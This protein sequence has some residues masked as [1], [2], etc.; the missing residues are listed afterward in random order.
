MLIKKIFIN[1]DSKELNIKKIIQSY[2]NDTNEISSL[3][4][5]IKIYSEKINNFTFEYPEEFSLEKMIS[6]YI[7][8]F[9]KNSSLYKD[10]QEKIDSHFRF[11]SSYNKIIDIN[12]INTFNFKDIKN[13]IKK[14]SGNTLIDLLSEDQ[15]KFGHNLSVQDID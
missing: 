15:G 3:E 12:D 10:L 5:I 6:V 4:N 8:Q 13:Y 14:V 11:N 2:I 1:M 7:S 9:D